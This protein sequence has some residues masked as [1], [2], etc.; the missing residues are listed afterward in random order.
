M[1]PAHNP[2]EIL[3]V[4]DDNDSI[5]GKA[6]RE[7]VNIKGLWHREVCCF[8]INLEKQL[9]LQ[10]RKDNHLW[11]GSCAGHFPFDQ[12]YEEAVVR[13]MEEELGI[14][15]NPK[16]LKELAKER[17]T[18]TTT[19]N[20]RFAKIYLLLKG[21]PLDEFKVDKEEV[22]EVRYFSKKDVEEL[23]LS[24]DMTKTVRYLIQKHILALIA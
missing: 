4:V 7:E 5:I 23:L 3:A 10:K 11:D 1:A 2:H 6:S 14:H 12:T 20:N 22:E 13:E 16:E 18:L 17:L 19:V 8:I 21:I 24:D 9:L 15:V